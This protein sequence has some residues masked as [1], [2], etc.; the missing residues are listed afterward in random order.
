M[1][2]NR[3]LMSLPHFFARLTGKVL[4]FA[5]LFLPRQI[6]KEEQVP[7]HDETCQQHKHKIDSR[8]VL[9]SSLFLYLLVKSEENLQATVYT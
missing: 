2:W 8:G 9:P 5:I 6:N 3:Q 1:M 4:V 7:S